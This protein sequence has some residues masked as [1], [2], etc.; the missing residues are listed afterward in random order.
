MVLLGEPPLALGESRRVGFVFLSGKEA[1]DALTAAG[2]FYLWENGL[3]G[4]A[5]ALNISN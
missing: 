3:F 4:E 2:K 5:T 1:V